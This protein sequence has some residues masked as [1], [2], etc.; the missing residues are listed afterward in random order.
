[1]Q[2]PL[3]QSETLLSLKEALGPAPHIVLKQV[4]T[5]TLLARWVLVTLE[6]SGR[7]RGL[8]QNTTEVRCGGRY[9]KPGSK[10]RGQG[11]K[12]L[13]SR[14]AWGT[15]QGLILKLKGLGMQF[16]ECSRVLA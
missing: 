5:G 15:Q 2:L 6:G 1:M 3:F 13:N 16:W 7:G 8:V 11:R 4:A 9:L 12:I 10:L 14:A